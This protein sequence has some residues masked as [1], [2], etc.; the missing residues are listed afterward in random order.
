MDDLQ[1]NP[2]LPAE[3][4]AAPEQDG[5]LGLRERALSAGAEADFDEAQAEAEAERTDE[6]ASA[7]T[8]S[9]PGDPD[10]EVSEAEAGLEARPAQQSELDG[11]A[12]A[13]PPCDPEPEPEEEEVRG[14]G[15]DLSDEELVRR[16]AVLLFA[17]PEPVSLG[18]LLKLLEGAERARVK[19]AL[20]VLS[21]R[22]ESA[23]LGIQLRSVAG[24][25]TLMTTPDL[26]EVVGR[27][28]KGATIEKVSPAALE[29]LA[30]VAYRQPVTKAEIEA[31]RGV[32]AGP[33]LRTLV[34]RGLVRV[35]GRADVPGHPL[36]YGTTRDFLDRF[37]LMALSDL[38]RDSELARG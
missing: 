13:E 1:P 29:T 3:S 11:E 34:D 16:S 7:A 33:I 15:W 21:N 20:E 9:E 26:G 18:R 30:V 28:A 5:D 32:Q 14:P 36:Q 24:G 2:D 27:L 38:P 19:A 17:S 12:S 4:E 25:H 6:P 23:D 22:L 37:G 31:I 35:T 8:P 10:P